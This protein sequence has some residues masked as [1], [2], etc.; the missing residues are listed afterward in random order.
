MPAIGGQV[1]LSA[2]SAEVGDNVGVIDAT[3]EG[4]PAEIAFNAKFLI[5]ALSVVDAPQVVLETTQPGRPGVIRPV[6][7][8]DFLHVIMPMHSVR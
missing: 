1:T 6:G 3:V 8:G 2:T 7:S 4:P 5:D